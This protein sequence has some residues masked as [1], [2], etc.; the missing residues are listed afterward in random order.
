MKWYFAIN[1]KERLELLVEEN[2]KSILISYAHFRNGLPASVEKMFKKKNKN[3][4]IDSGGFTNIRKPGF[5]KMEEYIEF[6]KQYDG[7][8]D[9]Y[10]VLDDPHVRKT[11]FKNFEKFK[12][13]GLSPMLVDHLWFPWN[14]FL[15]SPY[16]DE[17]K[18]C[19]GG[20][21][22]REKGKP[23][24]G[25]SIG[26]DIIH[27]RIQPRYE[28]A[29]AK[30][31]TSVHLLGAGQR[32][33]RFLPFVDVIDSFDTASWT[34]AP[35]QFMKI[36]MFRPEG[37]GKEFPRISFV[38]YN[39]R[40]KM[41]KGFLE[42]YGSMDFSVEKNRFRIAIREFKKYFSAVEKFH[43][44]WK[45]KNVERLKEVSLLR[46]QEL[47]PTI[48]SIGKA[49][50]D[51]Y[52]EVPSETA[53]PYKFVLQ[54]HWIGKG[55]H[56]DLRMVLRK[57][58]A[59]VGWTLDTQEKDSVDEP[60]IDLDMAIAANKDDIDKI[61]IGDKTWNGKSVISHKKDLIPYQWLNFQ[62]VRKVDEKKEVVLIIDKG[63]VE[64]G[65]QTKNFHEYFLNGK[66][67][68]GRVVV[69]L[70]NGSW[71]ASK[72]KKQI[73]YVLS[74]TDW[75]PPVGVS[76][77]PKAIRDRVPEEYQYWKKGDKEMRDEFVD[78]MELP[79]IVKSSVK[80]SDQNFAYEFGCDWSDNVSK[81]FIHAHIDGES[82]IVDVEKNVWFECGS[83]FEI[84]ESEQV[85]TKD[86]I[87]NLRNFD[88]VV[89][90]SGVE[91]KMLKNDSSGCAFEIGDGKI[92][93]L[94]SEGKASIA[95]EYV[96]KSKM[97]INIP[98]I[99]ADEKQIITGIVL[100][101][102]TVD[103]QNDIISAEVIEEAAHKFVAKYNK[104]SQMGLQHKVFG[105]LGIDLV[106]SWIAPSVVT[107][108]KTKVKK[109]TWIISVKIINEKLWASIKAG[110][111]TGFSIGGTAS[112][113]S[114]GQK[115]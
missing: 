91:F 47:E 87:S 73:P 95:D 43:A 86:N 90:K 103:A 39:D 30:P 24:K 52:S 75:M 20:T 41:T 53:G 1:K 78:N 70:V 60:V 99:K 62:G 74:G 101:P 36:T 40:K 61:E 68:E 79:K 82:I 84:D 58:K 69:R 112:V 111:I 10:V 77:L 114:T 109:G 113:T 110:K 56:T 76:A 8:I 32:L 55:H 6:I 63:T 59:L 19:W 81:S 21:V 31:F 29:I 88:C 15:D 33:G 12:K 71:L 14:K 57:K 107:I 83:F 104:L 97:V 48:Y 3:L 108:G 25:F 80:K 64:Y 16:K 9:E 72:P 28:K 65:A 7:I 44:K 89:Q 66:Q 96:E 45:K 54:Q 92:V 46:K 42:K 85:L 106:E 37:D 18:I 67:V 105:T 22:I 35:G 23:A 94:E 11:T 49:V 50:S 2:V 27:K 98:I 102:E 38:H 4:M 51:I 93:S 34:I 17:A 26:Y 13:E 100:E 115:D 5:V